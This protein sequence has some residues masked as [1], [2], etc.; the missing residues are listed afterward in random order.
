MS[1]E[2][3][4]AGIEQLVYELDDL[5]SELD[6]AEYGEH[7]FTREQ[8]KRM[9]HRIAELDALLTEDQIMDVLGGDE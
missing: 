9:R 2:I 6:L 8:T 5:R 7:S 4:R 3:Q 1:D